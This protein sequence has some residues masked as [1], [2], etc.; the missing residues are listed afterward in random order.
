MGDVKDRL[1]RLKDRQ[2]YRPVAP[3]IA[4]EDLEEVFGN[5]QKSPYMTMAPDV[6]ESVK[7]RF[8]AIAHF[9]GTARHQ[10]VGK[11]DEPWV[12][13]LLLAVRKLI[14]LGVLINTS[15]NTKGRP[16]VNTAAAC[17]TMLDELP[18]LDYVLIEDWLFSNP[19]RPW[20]Q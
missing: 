14:G 8:P 10:S 15:F 2:W 18:D 9:D 19:R 17:L 11:Q 12:H 13:E 16:L 4:D 5:L 1:N 20:K 6:R 3:M 7:R